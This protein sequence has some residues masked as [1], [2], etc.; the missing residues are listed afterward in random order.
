M[1]A[2]TLSYIGEISEPRLRGILGTLSGI[3]QNMG[4]LIINLIGSLTDWRSMALY[5]SG[6]PIAAFLG[7]CL[8]SELHSNH[9]NVWFRLFFNLF[10]LVISSYHSIFSRHLLYEPTLRFMF[11]WQ[12]KSN[13]RSPHTTNH[14]AQMSGVG[15]TRPAPMCL[16]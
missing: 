13:G 6:A 5:S 7:L 4:F 11:S 10:L 16:L 3:F 15:L 8:V 14:S 2:P 12:Y 9:P 1:Q